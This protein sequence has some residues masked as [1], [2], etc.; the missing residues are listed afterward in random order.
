MSVFF[1]EALCA[2]KEVSQAI[3]VLQ[4]LYK[5]KFYDVVVWL[6]KFLV[7][8]CS[9]KRVIYIIL[10]GLS[11][12]CCFSVSFAWSLLLLVATS[13]LMVISNVNSF[14]YFPKELLIALYFNLHHLYMP[15]YVFIYFSYLYR[16]KYL[17]EGF[18]LVLH[19]YQIW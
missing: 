8:L 11:C 4:Y 19:F 6:T 12:V 3:V 10:H 15:E 9:I 14:N 17:S 18:K 5:P 7:L 2:M 1:F 16:D 13:I